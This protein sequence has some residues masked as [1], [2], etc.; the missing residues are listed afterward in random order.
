M[1]TFAGLIITF[2]FL[3]QPFI[4]NA[5][6][7]EK[8]HTEPLVR[9][10]RVVDTNKLLAEYAD[11]KDEKGKSIKYDLVNFKKGLDKLFVK[12]KVTSLMDKFFRMLYIFQKNIK[13]KEK[14][15]LKGAD[16]LSILETSKVFDKRDM[17]FFGLI[18]R[19]EIKF[20]RKSDTQFKVYF[21]NPDNRLNLNKG[22]GF[23]SFVNGKCQHLKQL[24]LWGYFSF[25]LSMKRNGNL[26]VYHFRNADVYGD[27]GVRHKLMNL[28]LN[29]ISLFSVEFI[30]NSAYGKVKAFVSKKEFEVNHHTW[31]LRLVTKIVPTTYKREI[32]W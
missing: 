28:D 27:Y 14:I 7:D 8:C 9:V 16:V 10:K 19:V 26:Y 29:Y 22:D 1:K 17:P 31:L 30:K 11:L 25:F 3:L 18:K 2:C 6:T 4:T 23:K 5:A 21:K 15:Y 20:K 32:G 13:I 24:V 12:G